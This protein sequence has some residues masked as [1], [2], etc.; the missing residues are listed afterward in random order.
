MIVV[1]NKN[2]FYKLKNHTIRSF[3]LKRD[4]VFEFVFDDGKSLSVDMALLRIHDGKKLLLSGWETTIGK[5]NRPFFDGESLA[6][7]E[8]P[9]VSDLL[10]DGYI[11]K[12]TVTNTG[13]LLIKTSTGIC[14]DV[15]IN[16]FCK[17]SYYYKLNET[18]VTFCD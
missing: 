7:I 9:I 10:K 12:V 8:M 18:E 1:P 4:G 3:V 5:D 6:S 16:C 14:I 17:E 13:D 2:E 15:L 11:A